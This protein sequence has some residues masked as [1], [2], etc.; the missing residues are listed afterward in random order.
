M[1]IGRRFFPRLRTLRGDTG[2]KD[3]FSEYPDLVCLVTPEAGYRDLDVDT[4]EDYR[5]LAA[6]LNRIDS[7]H[8]SG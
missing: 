4:P 6:A 2:A 7:G 1:I 5:E 8:D 3:L